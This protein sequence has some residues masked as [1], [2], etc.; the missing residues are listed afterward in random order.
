MEAFLEVEGPEGQ[1]RVALDGAQLTIGRDEGN[2]L[3][4]PD[5]PTVSRRHALLERL[6]AGW[7][8]HDLESLN[9]TWVNG[10]PLSGGRPLYPGDEILI[11]D[12]L[13]VYRNQ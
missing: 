6:A 13:L 12:T 11:G 7:S 3:V 8:I 9:G 10:E 2:D 1:R 5:D 4:I